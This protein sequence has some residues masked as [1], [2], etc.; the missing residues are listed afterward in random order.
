MSKN[1]PTQ[2]RLFTDFCHKL[3]GHMSHFHIL[4]LF[5]EVHLHALEAMLITKDVATHEEIN[6]MLQKLLD[7]SAKGILGE[8][9]DAE[10]GEA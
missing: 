4:M 2:D 7:V 3:D 9:D 10:D 6:D 8:S 5:R 1:D